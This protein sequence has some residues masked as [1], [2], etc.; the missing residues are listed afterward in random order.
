MVRTVN[1]QYLI[2][3]VKQ[4][5]NDQE[6]VVFSVVVVTVFLQKIKR[7]LKK[8]LEKK[9]NAWNSNVDVW[10]ISYYKNDPSILFF[11][12]M[13]NEYHYPSKIC[14]CKQFRT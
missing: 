6:K 12:S 9:S 5:Y 4:F 14:C 3:L 11:Q 8:N 13:K 10:K 1:R 2:Q 7:Y